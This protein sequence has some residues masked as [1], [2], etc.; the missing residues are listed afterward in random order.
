M[1]CEMAH[2]G[3]KLADFFYQELPPMEMTEARKHVEACKEC[4]LE[5]E[6]LERIH[7][8]LRT[9]PDLDPPRRIVFSPPERRSW[10]SWL[11]WRSVAAASALA[12]LVAVGVS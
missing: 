11:E 4:R 2:L 8:T 1:R 9:F 12:A 10:L 5:V 7:L 6:Q 3:D